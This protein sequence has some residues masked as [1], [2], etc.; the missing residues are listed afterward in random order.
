[1]KVPSRLSRG[2]AGRLEKAPLRAEDY[3]IL[4]CLGLSGVLTAAGFFIL[5]RAWSGI[6]WRAKRSEAKRLHSIFL[7]FVFFGYLDTQSDQIICSALLC[8]AV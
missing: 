3:T 2:K 4:R 8:Y 7:H 1:M 6:A 5:A